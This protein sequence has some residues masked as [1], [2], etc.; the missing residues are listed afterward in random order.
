M[1]RK[2]KKYKT[3][4]Y[5]TNYRMYYIYKNGDMVFKTWRNSNMIIKRFQFPSIPQACRGHFSLQKRPCG[6][7]VQGE[8]A[9]LEQP[10]EYSSPGWIHPLTGCYLAT[11]QVFYIQKVKLWVN[12]PRA[13]GER[14]LCHSRLMPR[15]SACPLPLPFWQLWKKGPRLP[16]WAVSLFIEGQ[17]LIS[18]QEPS[19]S[20][21]LSLFQPVRLNNCLYFSGAL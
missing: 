11:W 10:Q 20:F 19:F 17:T 5:N 14:G 13:S 1:A 12:L 16:A 2:W 6:H 9:S 15:P 4:F 21:S 8:R 7:R 18:L 3:I